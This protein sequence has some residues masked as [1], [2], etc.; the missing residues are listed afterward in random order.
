ME[1]RKPDGCET[2]NLHGVT[3]GAVWAREFCRTVGEVVPAIRKHEDWIFGWF[4]NA[5]M[6]GYDRGRD[7]A[8]T[9]A[10]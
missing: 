6:A 8:E 2:I 9:P 1:K 4:C 7:E 5:I 10:S 3:D